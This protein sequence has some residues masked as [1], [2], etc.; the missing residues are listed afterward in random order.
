ME[1][2]EPAAPVTFPEER[3][4][5]E[6]LLDADILDLSDELIEDETF[7]DSTNQFAASPDRPSLGEAVNRAEPFLLSTP[8]PFYNEEPSA[9]EPSPVMASA[10]I[11]ELYM[12]HRD[13]LTKGA[14]V[15]RELL[16]ADPLNEGYQKRLMELTHPEKQLS[17]ES[18]D[19]QGRRDCW[20]NFRSG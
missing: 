10:T 15:Y 6:E 7:D 9:A 16:A 17:V 8:P 20:K 2:Q 19:C 14:D 5:E 12:Y 1:L 4:S 13:F 11:A 3:V 18:Q